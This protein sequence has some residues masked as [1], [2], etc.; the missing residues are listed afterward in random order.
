MCLT[1][2]LTEAIIIMKR[3]FKYWYLSGNW[4]SITSK[5]T[6]NVETDGDY[7]FYY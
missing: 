4:E 5:I 2:R 6:K 1:S 7:G 3:K